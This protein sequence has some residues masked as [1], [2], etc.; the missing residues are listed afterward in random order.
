MFDF[1]KLGDLSKIANQ[2]KEVQQQQE[3]FQHKQAELLQK[4]SNQL[5]ELISLAKNKG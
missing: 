2:A 1:N 5:Q 3:H 4:I